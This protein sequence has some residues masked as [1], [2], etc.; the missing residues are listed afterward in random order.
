LSIAWDDSLA[1]TSFSEKL[2]ENK[3][4]IACSPANIM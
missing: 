3:D 2:N 4:E 1:Y